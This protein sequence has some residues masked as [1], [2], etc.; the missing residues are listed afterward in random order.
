NPSDPAVGSRAFGELRRIKPDLSVGLWLYSANYFVG[1]SGQQVIPQQL[2]YVDDA[3]FETK[4][5]LIPHIFFTTGY[6]FLLNDDINAI[7]SIMVKYI[8]GVFKNDYQ[9]ELN[10]KFQY[11]DLV[12]AGGSYRQFDGYA[13]MLGLNVANTFN[14]GYS[15]DF[16]KTALHTYSKG[17]HEIVIGFLIGNR[18]GDTCPRNVW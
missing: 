11:R 4:G 5:K 18:Y 16:T 12:W 17:T 14:V 13:G 2:A 8:S 10:I 15:Y 9:A 6:R 3:S 7:P 1:I